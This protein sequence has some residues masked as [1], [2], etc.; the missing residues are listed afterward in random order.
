YSLTS[1]T[2]FDHRGNTIKTLQ[3]GGLVSKTQYDGA[4]RVAVSYLTDGLEQDQTGSSWDKARTLAGDTVL[5]QTETTY[6]F[7]GNPILVARR[8]RFH[9]ATAL[10][11]LGGPFDDSGANARVSFVSDYYDALDRLTDSVN[12]GTAGGIIYT[13]P[14]TV[15]AGSNSVLVTHRA[16]NAAGWLDA[17]TDPRGLVTKNFYDNL[18]RV[19][20]SV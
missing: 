13:R 17:V 11:P 6:D 20:R 5:S 18:G 7:N 2:W 16:Y 1:R 15:P 12:V 4:G 9:D 10:G 8:E 14:L 3:P 19:V